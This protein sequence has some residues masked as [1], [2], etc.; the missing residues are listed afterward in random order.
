MSRRFRSCCGGFWKKRECG[1]W[2]SGD[3]FEGLAIVWWRRSACNRRYRWRSCSR[4]AAV[5][6]SCWTGTRTVRPISGRVYKVGRRK[7]R[8]ESR[9]VL[10]WPR[11]NTRRGSWRPSNRCA[12]TGG[13]GSMLNRIRIQSVLVARRR[14]WRRVWS[15]VRAI[16]RRRT[17]QR[18]VRGFRCRLPTG[19]RGRFA[20]WRIRSGDWCGRWG[21]TSLVGRR[22]AGLGSWGSA[23][24]RGRG[25]EREWTGVVPGHWT[26]LHGH[27]AVDFW[28]LGSSRAV[29]PSIR[30][31]RSEGVT[32]AR[33]LAFFWL[34][35]ND[36]STW[37][38][39]VDVVSTWAPPGWAAPPSSAWR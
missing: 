15:K 12:V 16:W 2:A 24:P 5:C 17:N 36:F 7:R 4:I 18:S 11:R 38:R 14:N 19:V 27:R 35:I 30:R 32:L 31:P 8:R 28:G 33:A 25:R 10:S 23:A 6:L 26:S 37:T 34:F 13:S 21:M 20:S 1:V 9:A 22:W 3:R 39:G 29:G